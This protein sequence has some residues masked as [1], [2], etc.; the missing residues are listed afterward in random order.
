MSEDM[1]PENTCPDAS[2]NF[3]ILNFGLL[4]GTET[5]FVKLRFKLPSL[6]R[7]PDV[8]VPIT[9]VKTKKLADY[10]PD[11]FTI[12]DMNY[13]DL[14]NMIQAKILNALGEPQIFKKFF[15]QGFTC[16]DG[17]WIY[18]FSNCLIS[19]AKHEDWAVYYPDGIHV[20][21]YYV[22]EIK[23]VVEWCKLYIAQGK[24]QAAIFLSALTPYLLPITEALHFPEKATNAY[25]VGPSGCGKTTFAKLLTDGCDGSNAGV[26]LGT[27]AVVFFREVSKYSDQTILIDDLNLSSSARE[28]EKRMTRLSEL[29]QL[30]AS[31]GMTEVKHC[32]INKERLGLIITGEYTP[33]SAT[34]LNRCILIR[35]DGELQEKAVTQLQKTQ[36]LYLSFLVDFVQWIILNCDELTWVIKESME[37]GAFEYRGAHGD[38]SQYRGYTRVMAA[39][40]VLACAQ[41]LL[42]GFLTDT[43]AF[44][45]LREYE[46]IANLLS[47]GI[48]SAIADTLEAIRVEPDKSPVIRAIAAI[49]AEDRDEAVTDSIKKYADK[50]KKVFFVYHN[51][52][53]F[54]LENLHRYLKKRYG[55]KGS[56]KALSKVLEDADLLIS[57]GEENSGR[58][59][60]GLIRDYEDDEKCKGRHFAFCRSALIDLV[61]SEYPE[62]FQRLN[63]PIKQ[64]RPKK[65]R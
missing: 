60:P 8:T 5:M 26:N 41:M 3:E 56:S 10:I 22:K 39:H 1:I 16:I 19:K 13:R 12:P 55:L 18:V 20:E 48:N 17:D 44:S 57:C 52:I 25:V 47:D 50:E 32:R 65:Y 34:K 64:L 42:L 11:G 46:E 15:P 28:M 43:Q 40:K 9:D 36:N 27:D 49:F 54:K 4:H 30:S 35:L 6:N 24:A 29:I 61:L 31:G 14:I 63:S 33:P 23:P 53:Y 51:R 7:T 45:E 58:L 21:N 2:D 38:A 59:P 62:P 37:R